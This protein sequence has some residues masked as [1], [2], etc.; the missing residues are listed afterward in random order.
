MYFSVP[1]RFSGVTLPPV[2][3]KSVMN[4]AVSAWLYFMKLITESRTCSCVVFPEGFGVAV[5]FGLTELVGVGVGVEVGVGVGMGEAVGADEG[6]G[7]GDA[8]G[9]CS[10]VA[11]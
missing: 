8:F 3:T 6:G 1:K 11:M 5:G 7:V 4:C 9:E 10:C 2:Q